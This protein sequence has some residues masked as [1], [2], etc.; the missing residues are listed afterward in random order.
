MVEAKPRPC[1]R[2]SPSGPQDLCRYTGSHT[3]R[4]PCLAEW[5]AAA[6]LKCL[7]LFQK[8]TPHFHF[9]LGPT[10]FVAGPAFHFHG[11]LTC[12]LPLWGPRDTPR[13]L[14][15]GKTPL[16]LRP[17]PP[18][19]LLRH[20]APALWVLSGEFPWLA[21]Y[22]RLVGQA[23]LQVLRMSDQPFETSVLEGIQVTEQ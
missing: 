7:I 13:P 17:S 18:K 15:N 3:Q 9:A 16:G 11:L 20:S 10:N 8:G 6:V 4:G 22:C 19:R 21:V 2:A 1:S 23:P 5:S 14:Q 12:T